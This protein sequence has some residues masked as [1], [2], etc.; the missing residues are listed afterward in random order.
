MTRKRWT[1]QIQQNNFIFLE[2][3]N[4]VVRIICYTFFNKIVDV[5]TVEKRYNNC[6]R[7][8][9]WLLT[10]F[11]NLYISPIYFETFKYRIMP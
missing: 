1:S 5:I 6:W 11:I 3:W 2:K 7:K 9:Y 8:N 4:K 10:V